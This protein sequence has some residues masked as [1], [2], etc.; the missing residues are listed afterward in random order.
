MAQVSEKINEDLRREYE[1]TVSFADMHAAYEKKLAATAKKV[2]ID[3]FR[4]G[5]VP[6]AIVKKNYGPSIVAELAEE[7][8]S[9]NVKKL[10]EENRF[11]F[12]YQPTVTITKEYAENDDADFAFTLS[13]ELM[14][15]VPDYD[16]SSINVKRY[17]I[18]VEEQDMERAFANVKEGK[19]KHTDAEDGYQ[20]ANKDKIIMDFVGT[21]DGEKIE[22]GSDT[23][24][25]L[26]LGS[27]RLIKGFE[28]GLIGVKKGEE[29]TLDLTFPDPYH[30]K[31]LAGKPAEFRVKVKNVQKFTPA[32]FNDDFF[33]EVE[34]K[35]MEEFRNVIEN[36]LKE[37]NARR[38]RPQIKKELFD[39]LEKICDFPVPQKMLH[40]ELRHLKSSVK[41]TDE[42]PGDDKDKNETLLSI[43]ARRIR[44]GLFL[45][46]YA[47]QH[48]VEVTKDEVAREIYQFVRESN[49]SPEMIQRIFSHKSKEYDALASQF[50]GKVLEEKTVDKLM[51]TL[52]SEEALISGEEFD[53]MVEEDEDDFILSETGDVSG[54]NVEDDEHHEHVH[55]EHCDHDHVHD[56]DAQKNAPAPKAVNA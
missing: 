38:V 16:L 6:I 40:A 19:G 45:A 49:A 44:L 14:P 31:E 13:F 43:A 47:K 30:S 32:E 26:I 48:G 7:T 17:V 51:E 28:E 54:D 39:A 3:G 8:V 15:T 1:I 9:K 34:V 42:D 33:N 52:S 20:A 29:R 18:P 55:G 23:D 36:T 37:N 22:G 41:G 5:K 50:S 10:T 11:I 21:T 53:K 24:A 56:D 12:A 25:Q 35:D 27:G 46:H 4:K 2:R